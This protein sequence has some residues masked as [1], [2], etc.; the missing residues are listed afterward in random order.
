MSVAHQEGRQLTCPVSQLILTGKAPDICAHNKKPTKANQIMLLPPFLLHNKG[1]SPEV[2]IWAL[3]WVSASDLMEQREINSRH[4][5][6]SMEHKLGEEYFLTLAPSGD[7]L[8]SNHT[9]G[10]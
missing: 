1:G 7:L 9:F 10:Q 3:N 8:D 2:T 4:H 5:K 6:K